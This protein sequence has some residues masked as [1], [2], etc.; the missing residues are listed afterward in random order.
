VRAGR[1]FALDADAYFARPGPR[2]V[3]GVELLA[4]QLHPG[5]FGQGEGTSRAY[6]PLRTKRCEACSAPFFCRPASGCWCETVQVPPEAAV[7]V[8]SRFSDCL[9][10]A[11][12]PV[13]AAPASQDRVEGGLV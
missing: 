2:V 9:C 12:L 11:C 3:D 10:P 5:L 4:R 8:R 1:V 13:A 7:Q 6:R